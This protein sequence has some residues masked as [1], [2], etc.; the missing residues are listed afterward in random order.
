MEA[1]A[2]NVCLIMI[3]HV[4]LIAPARVRLAYPRPYLSPITEFTLTMHCLLNRHIAAC[5]LVF[6]HLLIYVPLTTV[7]TVR[8]K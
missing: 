2:R 4:C 7:L 5:L 8:V 1:T 6:L 3:H